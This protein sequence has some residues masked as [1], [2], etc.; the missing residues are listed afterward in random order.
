MP[1]SSPTPCCKTGCGVVSF[2][3]F[4]IDHKSNKNN[5]TSELRRGSAS[6]RGYD[7]KWNEHSKRYRQQQPLCENCKAKG[8]TTGVD[9]V[10]HIIP[11]QVAPGLKHDDDNL[12]SLCSTCHAIKTAEDKLKYPDIY[13]HG[14]GGG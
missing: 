13:K 1:R 14:T 7:H 12:Q 6:K 2:G 11:V 4:C 10:D 9:L 5:S 3:R 8:V